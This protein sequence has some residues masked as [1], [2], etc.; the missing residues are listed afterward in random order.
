MKISHSHQAKARPLQ[1]AQQALAASEA[2]FRGFVAAAP[3]G[4][5]VVDSRGLIVMVNAQVK[6]LFG[7]EPAELSGQPLAWLLP[8]RYRERHAGHLRDFF[9]AHRSRPMGSGLE[10]LARRKDGSE[11]PV[12]I[13]L[14]SVPTEQGMVV[15]SA[16]RDL[17]ARQRMEASLRRS[18]HQLANFFRQAPIGLV[19]L[20]A[21]G[22]I[23]RANQAQLELLGCS[24]E[25]CVGHAFEEFTV[26][27]TQC[28]ELLQ[29]LAARA[30]VRNFRLRLRCQPATIRHV[31]V[32]ANSLWG[33]DQFEYSS[34]FLR[35]I[36]DRVNL[37]KEILQ[38]SEREYRGIAHDLHD[39]LGQL[40]VG[41]VYLTSTLRA[42]LL[43]KAW[44]ETRQLD[45]IIEV[46]NEAIW[47]TRQLAHGL[48]PVKPESNGLM[49]ALQR[50]ATWTKKLFGV[51]CQFICRRPVLIKDNGVATHLFRIAQEAITNAVKHGH[52]GRIEIHLTASR[53]QLKLMIMDDGT[54][55]PARRRPP[56][57]MGLRIMR[58]RAGMI[59]GV[60]AI[61]QA[62]T[63]GTIVLCTVPLASKI[64]RNGRRI[65]SGKPPQP[66]E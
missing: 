64:G 37:E 21:S 10:L 30:T 7:Y 65:A 22:L 36:T 42:E 28:Q 47:Q 23:L 58:Y 1:L 57:G 35:D 6:T 38:V 11:F 45:R 2:K 41:T 60:L 49:A 52:P 4:I 25:A 33:A 32:D 55:M 66:K 19:W 63:G 17:T 27:P 5:V 16:I 26:E 39:G 29:R 18:E 50:Q 34:V 20:S 51:A 14:S 56:A 31:L 46:I 9:A 61:Q 40:L 15:F 3:D 54:G 59:G 13:T 12:E 62:T 43:A 24:A 44:P 48:Q 8:E 53:G